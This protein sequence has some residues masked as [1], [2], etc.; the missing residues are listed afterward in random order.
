MQ[1]VGFVIPTLNEADRIGQ[2][3]ASIP[4]TELEALGYR[5]TAI[6]VDGNS[7]DG[8]REIAQ[9]MG[10]HVVRQRGRGKGRALRQLF[11]D[12]PCDFGIVID[13]DGTYPA[14]H[15]VSMM[16]PLSDGADMVLMARVR[17]NGSAKTD[18]FNR[19]GNRILTGTANLLLGTELQDLCT[20]MWGFKSRV[21]RDL[22]FEANGFDIEAEVFARA[23]KHGYRL[24]QLEVPYEP[25]DDGSK[26]RPFRDGFR[27][28]RRIVREALRRRH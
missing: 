16:E 22:R 12:F 11:V 20:G 19:M 3:L 25:R 15:A 28:F 7:R 6:V 18:R 2:V 23:A 1:T 24:R 17:D 27:I 10:A 5:A 26:L 21:V 8:T 4:R 14:R 13:G 9:S